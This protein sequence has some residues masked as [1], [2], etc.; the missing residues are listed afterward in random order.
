MTVH[1]LERRSAA[2]GTYRGQS[3]DLKGDCPSHHAA[4]APLGPLENVHR[5]TVDKESAP[6]ADACTRPAA[7]SHSS[8][9]RRAE[10]PLNGGFC[11]AAGDHV[12]ASPGLTRF[13]PR[14][15]RFLFR[16]FL[17]KTVQTA[18]APS[19]FRPARRKE[20]AAGLSSGRP[21]KPRGHPAQPAS[22]DLYRDTQGRRQVSFRTITS[23]GSTASAAAPMRTIRGSHGPYAA[24]RAQINQRVQHETYL[25]T[26][27]YPPQAYPW[28]SRAHED[29]WRPRR[30]Q[31]ASRQGPQAPGSLRAG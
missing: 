29:P 11:D 18:G 4:K 31:R 27:R 19:G 26:F 17:S 3:L 9:D 24:G 5:T 16:S 1:N 25:P 15:P 13:T 6:M 7:S 14:Q 23:V 8:L 12:C 30:D 28:L 20:A 22:R 21:R 2:A 10:N